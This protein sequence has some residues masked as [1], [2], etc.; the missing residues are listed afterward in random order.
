MKSAI[1]TELAQLYC[2][3]HFFVDLYK[4]CSGENISEEVILKDKPDQIMSHFWI[5]VMK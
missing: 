2:L 5:L 1:S 3:I 4:W